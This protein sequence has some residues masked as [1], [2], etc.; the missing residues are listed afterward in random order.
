MQW[1][2]DGLPTKAF[3]L[4]PPHV[5]PGEAMASE[6]RSIRAVVAVYAGSLL[7][8]LALAICGA[9]VTASGS[10]FD[11]LL[12]AGWILVGLGWVV[13]GYLLAPTVSTFLGP[14][15]SWVRGGAPPAVW[16]SSALP[17]A[18]PQVVSDLAEK[19]SRG[20]DLGVLV[21]VLGIALFTAGV[22][23]YVNSLIGAVAGM[24]ILVAVA[25]L[26]RGGASPRSLRTRGPARPPG[27]QGGP[28]HREGP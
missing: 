4:A 26:W 12:A 11:T 19:L 15:A 3:S 22:V 27:S 13:V 8:A 17:E 18:N 20:T 21:A 5:H 10:V 2:P 28:A 23:A 1:N 6:T 7:T 16:P 24:L 25:V 9:F 14:G